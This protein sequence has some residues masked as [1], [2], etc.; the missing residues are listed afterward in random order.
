MPRATHLLAL[1][2]TT[3]WRT[4]ELTTDIEVLHASGPTRVWMPI[5]PASATPYQR[6]VGR[7]H[8][9]TP[10]GSARVHVD[11]R[12]GAALIAAVWPAHG[13]PRLTTSTRV[14]TRDYAVDLTHRRTMKPSSHPSLAPFLQPTSL[15]PTDGIVKKT[16]VAITRDAADDLTKARAIYD[17]IVENTARD[18]SVRG[19]GVGDIR[20]M[21]ESKDLRGK[22]A[23][24]NALF[25]GL[26]RAAGLPARDV[27]GIRVGKSALGYQSLGASSDVITSAQHCRA[28]AYL[29]GYGWTPVD[30]ADVRKVVL[31]EPPGGLSLSDATVASARTRLFGSWEMNWVAYNTGQ[32]I[33]L[34]DAAI[35]QV[36]PFLMYPQ[37]E[38]GGRRVDSLDPEHFT[39]RISVR[40]MTQLHGA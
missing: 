31:E 9:S 4:F 13:R 38:T 40:E 20:F 21:L 12:T 1:E 19:C 14:M 15:V 6:P 11:P 33:A 26:A 18:A 36:L 16:A 17:W 25:V 28:E 2:A 30:P 8:F 35:K 32:D 22:C 37:A 7:T 5:P 24:I 27:Y 34:P 29:T 3:A 23:D 10:G 39:Y